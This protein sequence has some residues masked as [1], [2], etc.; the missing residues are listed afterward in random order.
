MSFWSQTGIST[1]RAYSEKEFVPFVMFA[2]WRCASAWKASIQQFQIGHL[3]DVQPP[4]IGKTAATGAA[5]LIC[6][7]PHNAVLDS[8][9]VRLN[10]SVF[11][12][13]T[14]LNQPSVMDRC[15]QQSINVWIRTLGV[16]I[17]LLGLP[18]TIRFQLVTDRAVP[19]QPFVIHPGEHWHLRVDVIV[20][21]ND[22]LAM[23]NPMQPAHILL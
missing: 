15:S 22:L 11:S 4:P 18:R 17:L 9:I 13:V 7:K 19:L 5:N 1:G 3:I 2:R 8:V 23:V 14:Q 6:K 21:T 10:D 12:K 16:M 20:H